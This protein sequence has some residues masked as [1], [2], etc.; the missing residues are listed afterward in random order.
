MKR[1]VTGKRRYSRLRSMIVLTDAVR[2]GRD[3]RR[4]Y[5]CRFC[6]GWHLTK[7]PKRVE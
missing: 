2:R 5:Y 4:S 6:E 7:Q 3:E 1:C